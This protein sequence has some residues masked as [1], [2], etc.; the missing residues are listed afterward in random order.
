M[1]RFR[2]EDATAGKYFL[3]YVEISRKQKDT[4]LLKII[5]QKSQIDM[6]WLMVRDPPVLFSTLL[7]F[8]TDYTKNHKKCNGE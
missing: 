6:V 7:N 8:S 1:R 4:E 2:T 5:R 3:S